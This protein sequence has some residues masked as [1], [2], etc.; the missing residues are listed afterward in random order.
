MKRYFKSPSNWKMPDG[1]SSFYQKIRKKVGSFQNNQLV[2]MACQPIL[3][4]FMPN[5]GIAFIVSLY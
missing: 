1:N 3:G 4:Y 2:L 5:R